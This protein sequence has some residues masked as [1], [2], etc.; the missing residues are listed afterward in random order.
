[1]CHMTH[2]LGGVGFITYD[3]YID[4]IENDA[5]PTHILE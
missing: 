5:L 4:A 3:R 2:E 1:M